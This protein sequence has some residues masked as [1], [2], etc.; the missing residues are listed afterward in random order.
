MRIAILSLA[1]FHGYSYAAAVVKHPA[2]EL[3]LIWDEDA[4]RGAA[5]AK[6]FGCAFEP[7]LDRALAANID[8]VIITSANVHHKEIAVKAARADKH[9]LCEK[10]IA[11]TVADAEAMVAAARE[12]G[13]QFMTAFPCRYAP[14]VLRVKQAIEQGA[15]GEILAIKGTNHGRMPGG[16]FADPTLAGGGA[17]MDHT[18]HVADLIRWFLGK[19]FTSVYAEIDKRFHDIAADDCGMLTMELEGGAFATLDPSWSRPA[20]YPTWGDVTMEI[21]GTKGTIS[22]D[23][24]SQNLSLY[25]NDDKVAAWVPYGSDMDEGLV[26]DFIKCVTTN[27]RPPITGEDGLRAM[28]VALMAYESARTGQPVTRGA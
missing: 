13:V 1:H 5:A 14:P 2:A 18:V 3:A 16:W 10:P 23:A 28:E 20:A 25:N 21:V 8:A 9:I 19:E 26:N 6:Q 4:A 12:A 22:L 11:T 7:D 15:V 17:V 27:T 24:F